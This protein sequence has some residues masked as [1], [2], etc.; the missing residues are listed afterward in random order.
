MVEH[1]YADCDG[2]EQGC[3]FCLGGLEYCSVCGAFEGA[4]PDECPGEQ[5]SDF[6]S[7]AVYSGTMNFRN[8]EW[9]LECCQVMRPVHDTE[10]YMAEAGYFMNEQGDW[11]K[12]PEIK[13]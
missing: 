1:K 5:M 13:N 8:G 10:N 9:I 3:M 12:F 11:E 2:C 6:L 7:G 4:T